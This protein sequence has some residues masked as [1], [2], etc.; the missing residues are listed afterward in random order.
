M[1]DEERQEWAVKADEYL[2]TVAYD[3]A[4]AYTADREVTRVG[5]L[6]TADWVVSSKEVIEDTCGDWLCWEGV[7][8]DEVDS[9]LALVFKR[10]NAR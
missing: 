10:E 5:V 2:H 1:T 9:I 8:H 7:D 6:V 4:E 3:I